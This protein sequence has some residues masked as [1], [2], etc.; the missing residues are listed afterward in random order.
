MRWRRYNLR[1]ISP[2]SVLNFLL[3]TSKNGKSHVSYAKQRALRLP[4]IDEASIEIGYGIKVKLGEKL[5]R[6]GRFRFMSMEQIPVPPEIEEV[7]ES[8][9]EQGYWLV[10]VA[11]SLFCTI[12]W[13]WP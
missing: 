7:Q 8:C 2:I 6:V 9:H 12:F 5:V 4:Q 1:V 3:V 13:K 10:Y 11:I